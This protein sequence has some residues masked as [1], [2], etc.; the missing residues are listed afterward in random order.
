MPDLNLCS[1]L[2]PRF[3]FEGPSTPVESGDHAWP[4]HLAILPT[5]P[6]PAVVNRPPAYKSAP[7]IVRERTFPPCTP[8][9]NALH[10]LPSHLATFVAAVPPAALKLPPAYSAPAF[11]ASASTSPFAPVPSPVH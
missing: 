6:G 8:P 3:E 7:A 4:S 9:P 10:W 5:A 11:H 1:A 2:T